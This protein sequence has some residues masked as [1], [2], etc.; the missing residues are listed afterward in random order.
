MTYNATQGVLNIVCPTYPII[1][2]DAKL[3]RNAEWVGR[4]WYSPR[5]LRS[6]PALTSDLR[7]INTKLSPP[8]S[9]SNNFS[10][11]QI[12]LSGVREIYVH[13]PTLSDLA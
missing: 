1:I 4:E 2:Y 6:G 12:D 8:Q 10:T 7:D 3:L 9:F 13:S 11:G 5:N